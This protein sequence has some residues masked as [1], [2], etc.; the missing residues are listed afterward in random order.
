MVLQPRQALQVP[1]MHKPKVK[2]VPLTR[3]LSPTIGPTEIK[4]H[5]SRTLEWARRELMER[6]TPV[7]A[8]AHGRTSECSP[9]PNNTTLAGSGSSKSMLPP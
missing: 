4:D 8:L 7:S 6:D 9:Y 1:N 3:P 5:E 2:S